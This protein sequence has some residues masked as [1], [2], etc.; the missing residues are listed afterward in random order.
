MTIENINILRAM[1]NTRGDGIVIDVLNV[2]DG[3]TGKGSILDRFHQIGE[4]LTA[5]WNGDVD[6]E[7]VLQEQRESGPPS[8]R[9]RRKHPTEDPN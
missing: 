1:I 2:T 5:V 6:V 9:Q 8:R 7:T 4:T 3:Q